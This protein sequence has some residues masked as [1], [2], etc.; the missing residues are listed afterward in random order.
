MPSTPSKAKVLGLKGFSYREPDGSSNNPLIPHLGAAH[1]P[2]ARSVASSHVAPV[3]TLPDPG[4]VFDTLL[5]RD[6]DVEHPTG[7]SSM[8]FAFANLIIHSL[9]RTNSKDWSVNDTSSYL[10][11]SPLYGVDEEEQKTVRNVDGTGR[12]WNDVFA[13]KRILA[14]PP[15]VGALLVIFNRNHN[16]CKIALS[17]WQHSN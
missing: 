12:L 2:Y 11:L 9:F 16:V 14:M 7:L 17:G 8:F 15:S 4:L 5:K 13:D 10:D 3:A 6:K 1:T